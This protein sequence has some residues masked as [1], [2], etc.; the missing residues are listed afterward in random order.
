MSDEGNPINPDLSFFFL[1]LLKQMDNPKV[2]KL[3]RAVQHIEA[4]TPPSGMTEEKRRCWDAM[5]RAMHE[6]AI[7]HYRQEMLAHLVE[8]MDATPP[9][10]LPLVP[11]RPGHPL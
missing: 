11:R 2:A 8:T 1:Y 5:R 9:L 3:L 6:S 7:R 10:P 4:W